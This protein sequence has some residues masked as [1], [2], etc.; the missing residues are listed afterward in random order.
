MYFKRVKERNQWNWGEK[1]EE[2]WMAPKGL[3]WHNYVTYIGSM[4]FSK[5]HD[6]LEDI[7][8]KEMMPPNF[9]NLR[10]SVDTQI[11]HT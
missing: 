4:N 5:G 11:Q 9:P 1:N 3:M 6:T 2:K 10:K 7:L 8:L